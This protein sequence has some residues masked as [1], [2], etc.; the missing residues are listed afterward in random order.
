MTEKDAERVL[1]ALGGEAGAFRDKAVV[2]RLIKDIFERSWN[3]YNAQVRTFNKTIKNQRQT[4]QFR[5]FETFDTF[6]DMYNTL[7]K[8]ADEKYSI[9]SELDYTYPPL[10]SS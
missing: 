8:E 9:N 1:M 6:E 7:F 10:P 5:T 3:S 4:D 2:D